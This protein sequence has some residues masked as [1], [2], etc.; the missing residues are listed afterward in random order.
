VRRFLSTW[1]PRIAASEAYLATLR[2]RLAAGRAENTRIADDATL[3]AHP[4]DENRR[5]GPRLAAAGEQTRQGRDWLAQLQAA[6]ATPRPMSIEDTLRRAETIAFRTQ[7]F[8]GETKSLVAKAQ[9]SSGAAP[10][11]KLWTDIATT[12]G[13]IVPN[14]R[15]IP[16]ATLEATATQLYQVHN[17]DSLRAA[18]EA[19]KSSLASQYLNARRDWQKWLAKGEGLHRRYTELRFTLPAE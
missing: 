11:G 7:A 15:L 16:G 3:A 18:V 2:E 13:L 12:D 5:L 9:Q 19:E 6:S 17:L 1:Q 14:L 10:S 4:T 8:S